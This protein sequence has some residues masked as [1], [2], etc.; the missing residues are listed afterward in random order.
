MTAPS[1]HRETGVRPSLQRQDVSRD[2]SRER[3]AGIVRGRNKPRG[4]VFDLAEDSRGQNT[5]R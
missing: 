3:V 4:T 2:F 1:A 5:E